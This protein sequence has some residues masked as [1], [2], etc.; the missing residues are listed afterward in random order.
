MKKTLSKVEVVFR[1]FFGDYFLRFLLSWTSIFPA[2][3][4]AF[5]NNSELTSKQIYFTEK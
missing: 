2:Y 5:L 4:A 3:F 1:N